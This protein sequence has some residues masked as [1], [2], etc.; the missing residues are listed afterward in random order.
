MP[1]TATL[2]FG[3]Q[4]VQ[5]RAKTITAKLVAELQP[6][7]DAIKEAC[8]REALPEVVRALP[9]LLDHVDV[10]T[11]Q[12]ISTPEA[13][14]QTI[15]RS[16]EVFAMITFPA[17]ALQPNAPHL[18]LIVDVVKVAVDRRPLPEALVAAL[19]RDHVIEK[20]DDDGNVTRE[21]DPFWL[22]QDFE[23]LASFVDNFR[24]RLHYGGSR[25]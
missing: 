25:S 16:P 24:N 21:L 9:D 3:D 6:A 19:E 8:F 22:D 13:F 23:G 4:A 15:K 5:L 11:G 17:F 2:Q 20:T 10:V 18:K 12:I 1:V 14:V 7:L